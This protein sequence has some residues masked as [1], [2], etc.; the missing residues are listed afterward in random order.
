MISISTG[1]NKT[2]R[3]SRRFSGHEPSDKM[4]IIKCLRLNVDKNCEEIEIEVPEAVYDNL[5]EEE[6]GEGV[7]NVK[8]EGDTWGLTFDLSQVCNPGG[9]SGH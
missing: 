8:G 5:E 4:V 7:E 2:P 1:R 9:S 3:M 6:G